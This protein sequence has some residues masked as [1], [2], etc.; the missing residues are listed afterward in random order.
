MAEN[1]LKGHWRYLIYLPVLT[2][3]TLFFWASLH[4]DLS[5]REAR[6]G[7]P[8]LRMQE[9]KGW[10]IPRL[11]ENTLRTK[12]PLWHWLAWA[13]TEVAGTR[14][15]VLRFP[16]VLAG[17][18]SVALTVW[19]GLRLFSPLTGFL[20]GLLLALSWRTIYLSSHARIDMLFAFFTTASLALLWK[21][22]A[23]ENSQMRR[24]YTWFA[25]AALS[26][27]VLTKGPLGLL[28]PLMT[29]AGFSWRT[30]A[31]WR[32]LPWKPL[33]GI[34][35]AVAGMWAGAAIWEGGPAF[36]QMLY[37]ELVGRLTSSEAIQVHH[38]PFY[39]Y[40]PRILVDLA[41]WGFFLPPALWY[42]WTHRQKEL[43]WLFPALAFSLLFIFLSLLSGKRGDY[44]L[45]LYPFAVIIVAVYF[46]EGMGKVSSWFWKI[47]AGVLAFCMVVFAVILATPLYFHEL[48]PET[49]LRFL[50]ARDRWSVGFLLKNHLPG[51]WFLASS[52]LVMLICAG[53]SM[54]SILRN[55]GRQLIGIT[56]FWFL[57]TVSFVMGPLAQAIDD[58]TTLR[59]F[60]KEVLKFAGD[61]PL[62]HYGEPRENLLYYLD[63][64][65]PTLVDDEILTELQKPSHPLLLG[66][67]SVRQHLLD[68]SSE[69]EVVL[70]SRQPFKGYSL[71]SLKSQKENPF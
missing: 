26:G 57:A 65:L 31:G 14:E 45:P 71:L 12:P 10:L 27:A 46:I 32:A 63:R 42:G 67:N 61:R 16:S 20:S 39:F 41:P 69:L 55:K 47:P 29:M 34:P 40:I 60:A 9:N 59:P 21:L 6:E 58:Q 23:E 2:G 56:S 33:I 38:E 36:Q 22:W 13:S 15:A 35:L 49:Q 25:G 37:Q 5:K 70:D 18:G 52:S 68:L 17:T 30:R 4:T 28:F 51:A 48:D 62:Y 24:R 64:S 54:A 7:I 50:S 3:F 8:V 11:D 44:L 43:P 1:V 53:L 66:K 19:F